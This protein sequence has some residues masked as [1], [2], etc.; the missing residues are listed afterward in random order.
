MERVFR[1]LRENLMLIVSITHHPVRLRV[2]DPSTSVLPR[3]EHDNRKFMTGL[4]RHVSGDSR[5]EVCNGVNV[6]IA[7]L[8]DMKA[9]DLEFVKEML[10]LDIEEGLNSL[11]KFYVDDVNVG[12]CR[13]RNVSLLKGLRLSMKGLAG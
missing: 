6:T 12:L 7:F 11:A 2:M 5:N 13:D 1:V 4:Q 9:I 3:V 8:V 10:R